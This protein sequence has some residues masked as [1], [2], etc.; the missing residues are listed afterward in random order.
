MNKIKTP[1]HNIEAEKSVI[2]SIFIDKD[3][4]YQV[5]DL[6]STDD[7]YDEKHKIIWDAILNL[8]ARHTPV[9]LLTVSDFLEKKGKLEIIGGIEYLAE[10]A[11]EVP[12]SAHIGAYGKIVKE[13]ATRRNMITAGNEIIGY[14]FDE[15]KDTIELLEKTE[16][17]VFSISQTFLKDKF[18]HIKDILAGR[19]DFFSKKHNGEIDEEA[20]KAVIYSHFKGIDEKL[21]GF[22]PS[23]LIILAARPAMGKTALALNIAQNAAINGKKN[24]GL[25]SLE[26]SK[27]QLVDR[28]F[29]STIGVDSW[30]L[31]KGML[32]DED[33]AKLGMGL[34]QLGK[35]NIF[36]DDSVGASLSEVKAKCRRLKMEHGLDIIVIDYLQLMTSGNP[37]LAANRVNEI[38]EISRQLKALAR[39]LSV[40]II[41]LSQLSR[42]VESR[43]GKIPQLSDLRDSGSIE[44][45]A[46]VVFMMYREEYYEPDTERKGITDLFIRKNR[47]GPV[48]RI[49][50]KFQKEQ[51]KFFDSETKNLTGGFVG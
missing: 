24:V 27:E 19:F 36:I 50:L 16:K 5:S 51:M 32:N 28:L 42:A 26:M 20:E 1:P 40:P 2:G 11:S 18:V 30:K 22:K 35:A 17:Q 23:E 14:G 34:D 29:C 6:I 3:S 10:I 39:G 9:D 33:F 31:H 38:S 46:D 8:Q 43:P 7:F 44:Q 47:H 49:E 15:S 12:T 41:A 25:F 21:N 4:F 45:D 48:G 13:T 37:A